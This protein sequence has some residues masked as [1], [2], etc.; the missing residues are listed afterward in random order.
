MKERAALWRVWD[1]FTTLIVVFVVA[2]AV[3]LIG[4]RVMG[5]QVY[6][7]IS[8]SMEP[9]YSVGDLLYVKQVDPDSVQVGDPITFVLNENLVVATHRVIRVDA[10]NRR[11]YTQGD[12]NDTAD[13][14]PVHFNN[15]IGVP[16][17]SIPRLGYVSDF[18]QH[19]PGTYI[20]VGA[21]LIVLAALFLPDLLFKDNGEEN[22]DKVSGKKEEEI[23]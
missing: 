7:V 10:E 4:L 1:W 21:G 22:A 9:T 3:L 15:L 20:A 11:F 18:V 6:N 8:G 17:F 12:A 14:A 13:A 2:A 16:M 5:Y 23:Q 19:P